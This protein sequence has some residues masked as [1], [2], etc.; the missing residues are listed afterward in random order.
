MPS[1]G[2]GVGL[3]YIDAVDATD[4]F[5]SE[6]VALTG[7]LERRVTSLMYVECRQTRQHNVGKK[8]N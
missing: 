6:Y 4:M 8:K 1:L 3:A 5:D 2:A 7:L